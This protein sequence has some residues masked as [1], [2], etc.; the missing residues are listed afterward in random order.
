[1]KVLLLSLSFVVFFASLG[2]AKD[3]GALERP[4]LIGPHYPLAYQSTTFEPDRAFNL[5]SGQSFVQTSFTRLNTYAFSSTSDKAGNPSGDPSKFNSTLN[6]GYS[7]YFDGEIDRRFFRWYQG[8]S[9]GTELQITYRDLRFIP[10]KLD[11][12][13]EGF[14][15]TLG[16]GNQGR[17]QTDRDQLQI[18]IHDNQTGENIVAITNGSDNFQRESMTLGLKFKVRETA[19]EA[20]ALVISSNFNDGYVQGGLNETGTLS[21]SA[22]KNFNDTNYALL[23]SSKFNSWALHAGFSLARVSQSLLPKA[24]DEMYYF[25]LGADVTLGEHSHFLMQALEYTSPFPED[26]ISTISADVREVSTGIRW[27]FGPTAL[28]LGLIENQSQGPQNI[29]IAYF[30]NFMLSF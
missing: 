10:G 12:Q 8:L 26:N 7:V 4:F 2:T 29:D 28:E 5:K 17:D 19:N 25:F 18:Y 30:S 24:P 14:H 22:P 1:M 27:I 16:I 13:I 20:I 15:K 11:S 23:Y 6:Q 9:D 21:K 3:E